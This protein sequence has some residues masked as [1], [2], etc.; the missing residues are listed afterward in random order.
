MPS[1]A[2]I[3]LSGIQ[4]VLAGIGVGLL[5]AAPK[6]KQVEVAVISLGGIVASHRAFATVE[7]PDHSKIGRSPGGFKIRRCRILWPAEATG[8][9]ERG[10]AVS[11]EDGASGWTLSVGRKRKG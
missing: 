1:G 7:S 11:M 3:V 10:L 8:G 4:L 9:R 5:V 6:E 2:H